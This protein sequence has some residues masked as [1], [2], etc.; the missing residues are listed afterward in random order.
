M[1]II[2]RSAIPLTAYFNDYVNY[3]TRLRAGR[4][5][6]R[7]LTDAK[8]NSVLKKAPT[9]SGAYPPTYENCIGLSFCG[10]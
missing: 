3:I 5:E 6:I 2:Q 1:A 4:F 9:V 8:K 7:N 10:A